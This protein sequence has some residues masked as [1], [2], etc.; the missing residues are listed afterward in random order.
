MRATSLEAPEIFFA[1]S[2]KLCRT[3]TWT[4]L[5]ITFC[6]MEPLV[7]LTYCWTAIHA[8][9][10]PASAVCF[11]FMPP[12]YSFPPLLVLSPVL[13][14]FRHFLPLILWTSHPYCLISPE[15]FGKFSV[16]QVQADLTWLENSVCTTLF[17]PA[18][19]RLNQP[20]LNV[21]ITFFFLCKSIVSFLKPQETFFSLRSVFTECTEKA[22]KELKEI[23]LKTQHVSNLQITS[24][25]H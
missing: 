22:F 14:V 13:T 9:E 2:H 23:S 19:L 21:Q 4:T 10:R 16:L 3:K 7:F 20:C 24:A 5:S 12:P 15:N 17:N 8:G 11:Y 18:H 6:F 25:A 1:G